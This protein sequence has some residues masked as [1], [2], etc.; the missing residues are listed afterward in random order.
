MGPSKLQ[1]KSTPYEPITSSRI[2]PSTLTITV[3]NWLST[4]EPTPHSDSTTA[5]VKSNPYIGVA[6]KTVL[7]LTS[8]TYFPKVPAELRLRIWR[9]VPLNQRIVTIK[10]EKNRVSTILP[11]PAPPLLHVCHE[12]RQKMLKDY[13]LL[14]MHLPAYLHLERDVLYRLRGELD[15][16]RETTGLHESSQILAN[17]KGC[18]Q[19]ERVASGI[20]SYC[21]WFG[22]SHGVQCG[23]PVHLSENV[24][25][26][27]GWTRTLQLVEHEQQCV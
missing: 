23:Q 24:Y 14:N 17:S 10:C 8:F 22:A 20:A 13:K 11:L 21:V 4:T 27:T 1:T 3:K 9:F 19:L 2:R 18:H 15:E 7:A 25:N 6:E 5:T 16:L 26:V 12:S